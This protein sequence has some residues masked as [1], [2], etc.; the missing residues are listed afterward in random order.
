MKKE[1]ALSDLI[2]IAL[3]EDIGQADRTSSALELENLS[4]KAKLQAKENGIFFG[5]EVF[6]QVFKRLDSNTSFDWQVKDGDALEKGQQ[7]VTLEGSFASLLS[8]ERTALNFLQH[9][10]GIATLAAKF[11]AKVKDY[12]V[13]LLDTRK[14]TPAMRYL[15]K[16]A[17]VA[18]GMTNHRFGLFDFVL[19]KENHL[20]AAGGITNAV[21]QIRKKL[22]D[23][24]AI[25]VEVTN[26]EQLTEAMAVKVERAMLD[27]F[28][29][30]MTRQAVTLAKEKIALEASGNISLE[31]IQQVAATGVDYISIGAVTHSAKALDLS[32]LI[33]LKDKK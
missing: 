24:E 7:I 21:C 14:T 32:L 33:E 30:E 27:N 25:E 12:P 16:A 6:Q 9:L 10:C 13:T 8:A 20:A 31:N 22:G 19:L 29:L 15:E 28:S 17:V 18:G 23:N 26:L 2:E 1:K 5:Q 3:K 4:A 11:K